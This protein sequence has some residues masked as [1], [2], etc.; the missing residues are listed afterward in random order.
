MNHHQKTAGTGRVLVLGAH[1]DDAVLGCGGTIARYVGE[2]SEVYV[3][4]ATKAFTPDWTPEYVANQMKELEESNLIL[5]IKKTFYLN[6]PAASLDT[7]PQKKLNDALWQVVNEVR[8]QSVFVN[9]QDDVNI[10]H[11]LLFDAALVATRPLNNYI[12]RVLSY[13]TF[14]FGQLRAPFMPNVYVAIT[15]MLEI[16]IKAMAPFLSEMRP[17][18]HPR[19]PEIITAL[20]KK[21]GSEAGIPLAEAFKLI[22]EVI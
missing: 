15:G 7:V 8:P 17:Y 5:G 12:K 10:D 20:A 1:P 3:C 21:W 6:F 11:R 13:S 14:E 9:N 4:V 22:R 16:K 18:P 19:S 2:G